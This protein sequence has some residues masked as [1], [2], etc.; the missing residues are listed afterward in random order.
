MLGVDDEVAFPDGGGVENR[1]WHT[2]FDTCDKLAASIKVEE[3]DDDGY[4]QQ[5]Q[6]VQKVQKDIL[7]VFETHTTTTDKKCDVT[8]EEQKSGDREDRRLTKNRRSAMVS[9]LRRVVESKRIQRHRDVL[10]G[11]LE[12]IVLAF[13]DD[14]SAIAK[15][16]PFIED[17]HA[18]CTLSDT[19]LDE[20]LKDMCQNP[21]E[22]TAQG[23]R[24]PTTLTPLILLPSKNGALRRQ[25]SLRVAQRLSEKE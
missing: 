16:R 14:P 5:H 10:R 7:K 19:K 1:C 12:K 15:I 24:R 11:T 17:A 18:Q 4:H 23:E 3:D 20:Q 2:Q 13:R 22:F 9:R 21:G 8:K 6:K 25:L